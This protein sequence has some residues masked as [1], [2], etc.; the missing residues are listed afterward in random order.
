[1]PRIF[2]DALSLEYADSG[3]YLLGVHIAD[4]SHYVRENGAIDREA[5]ERAT[6]VYLV[7][8][9]LPMLPEHLSNNICSL[10]EQVDRLTYTCRMEIS[11]DGKIERYDIFK[12]II[13]SNARLNY[14]EVQ[15]FF[16]NGSGENISE[17]V[18]E[19]LKG[20]QKLA[21]INAQDSL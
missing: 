16:D 20:L 2:D 18:G 14:D 7:D 9:V 15:E 1:M 11:P 4:V 19:V 17:D 10:N 3:N 5:R 6:S 21:K 8:R 13:N 12:S